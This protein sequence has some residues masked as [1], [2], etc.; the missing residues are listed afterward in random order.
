M[1]KRRVR[2]VFPEALR[3]PHLSMDRRIKSGGDEIKSY[4][5]AARAQPRREND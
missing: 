4:L 1:Q 5:A 3:R 2:S